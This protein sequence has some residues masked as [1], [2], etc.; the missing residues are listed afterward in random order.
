MEAWVREEAQ[1][2]WL[3]E[4]RAA[5]PHP[6]CAGGGGGHTPIH[7]VVWDAPRIHAVCLHDLG[8]D[9]YII[10]HIT[11]DI[12]I[13]DIIILRYSIIRSNKSALFLVIVLRFLS[14]LLTTFKTMGH[15]DSLRGIKI[16]ASILLEPIFS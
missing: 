9:Q 14:L 5:P 1:S 10:P 2:R 13:I 7:K 8:I 6:V 11:L 16:T 4:M 15:S 3:E 12:C